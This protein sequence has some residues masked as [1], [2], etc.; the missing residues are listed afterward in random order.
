MAAARSGCKIDNELVNPSNLNKWFQENSGYVNGTLIVWG[1]ITRLPDCPLKFSYLLTVSEEYRTIITNLVKNCKESAVVA[2]L[3][4]R[5][6]Y[7]FL[8]EVDEDGNFIVEDPGSSTKTKYTFDELLRLSVYAIDSE[9]SKSVPSK[10]I[11][12]CE[13][14]Q[15]GAP[16]KF[17]VNLQGEEDA[18]TRTVPMS[19][20]GQTKCVHQYCTSQFYS[21]VR[22]KKLLNWAC[23]KNDVAIRCSQDGLINDEVMFCRILGK[24]CVPGEGCVYNVGSM[25]TFRI[26]ITNFVYRRI[27]RCQESSISNEIHSSIF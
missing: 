5:E 7:I 10:Y 11:S 27:N 25:F 21:P 6:H 22:D 1:A 26:K 24:K 18:I 12:N 3:S 23:G 14:V 17:N 9:E 19:V 20:K 8:K 15:V 4:T 13:P 2:R 16:V